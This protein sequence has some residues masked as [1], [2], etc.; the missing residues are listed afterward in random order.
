[1]FT[2]LNPPIKTEQ[3]CRLQST[4]H[5]GNKE[6]PIMR[7]TSMHIIILICHALFAFT[8]L[9]IL[10]FP[11][12]M[13]TLCKVNTT[14]YVPTSISRTIP[15]GS[16]V[17]EMA[18]LWKV[19]RLVHHSSYKPHRI[20]HSL[21][22]TLYYMELP[23]NVSKHDDGTNCREM[24]AYWFFLTLFNYRQ[25]ENHLRA[26][27]SHIHKRAYP[28]SHPLILP[29]TRKRSCLY[30]CRWRACLCP[31]VG[32]RICSR[33]PKPQSKQSQ[34]PYACRY[35]CVT[36]STLI[37]PMMLSASLLLG[38]SEANVSILYTT[39]YVPNIS[40]YSPALQR[41]NLANGR[42]GMDL[43]Q[44]TYIYI[45]INNHDVRT[46]LLWGWNQTRRSD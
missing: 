29:T 39:S 10:N 21:R 17:D 46:G 9:L 19:R 8:P 41:R 31:D 27:N 38:S 45:Y 6:R 20:L 5:G 44:T 32:C 7:K 36:A 12:G 2:E 3:H 23:A 26:G 18:R 11:R 40:R 33:C 37:R 25:D 28:T 42:I 24:I 43:L 15:Y 22:T 4:R 13:R 34:W 30:L 16:A 35:V 14:R 1:M